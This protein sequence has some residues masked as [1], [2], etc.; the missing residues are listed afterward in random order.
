M[1]P[2]EQGRREPTT[3]QK[4]KH[5]ECPHGCAAAL[6]TAAFTLERADWWKNIFNK[7][8]NH[9]VFSAVTCSDCGYTEFYLR[10]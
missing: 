3:V 7:R 5:F 6:E 8:A 2:T 4:G 10:P 9:R 1:A